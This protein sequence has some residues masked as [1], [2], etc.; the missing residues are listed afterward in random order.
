MTRTQTHSGSYFYGAVKFTVR[1]EREGMRYC[2]CDY[3]RL[4]RRT[5]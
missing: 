2:H 4:S 5:R 3:C 1:G